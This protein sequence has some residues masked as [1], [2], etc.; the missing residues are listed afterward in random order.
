MKYLRTG[1]HVE[2]EFPD[3]WHNGWKITG[4]VIDTCHDMQGRQ[5][6]YRYNLRHRDGRVIR[7][8]H[9]ECARATA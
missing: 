3:G 2:V 4:R 5:F 7:E 1:Q 6:K 9:P 8:I